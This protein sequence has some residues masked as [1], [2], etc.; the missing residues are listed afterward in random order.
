MRFVSR[1]NREQ[2]SI[3]HGVLDPIAENSL[4]EHLRGEPL[5]VFT[6]RAN[7]DP[8]S[9]MALGDQEH[10]ADSDIV[11]SK[12][13]LAASKSSPVEVRHGFLPIRRRRNALKQK[14]FVAARAVACS[15]VNEHSSSVLADNDKPDQVAA[16]SAA[17]AVEQILADI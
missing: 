10:G 8:R 1:I 11:W 3:S 7:T 17:V 4:A 5:R 13:G 12:R 14:R 2:F 16:A 6:V 9:Q 15:R